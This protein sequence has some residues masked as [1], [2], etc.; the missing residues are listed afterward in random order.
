MYSDGLSSERYFTSLLHPFR[1]EFSRP[2][3]CVKGNEN[4][5]KRVCFFV[6]H[7]KERVKENK[8]EVAAK[9]LARP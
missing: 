2:T 6:L 7:V 9:V 4:E 1:K 3:N 5:L 8:G